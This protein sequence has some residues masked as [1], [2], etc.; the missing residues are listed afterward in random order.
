MQSGG[1]GATKSH[2]G[3]HAMPLCFE[4]AKVVFAC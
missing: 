3:P 2:G 4:G 1:V